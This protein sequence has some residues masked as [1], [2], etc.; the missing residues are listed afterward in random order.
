M[1][2]H[3]LLIRRSSST[4]PHPPV[5]IRRSSSTGPHPPALTHRSSS[6]GPHPLVLIHL[7][8]HRTLGFPL[9]ESS[10]LPCPAASQGSSEINWLAPGF[11]NPTCLGKVPQF[12]DMVTG[13]A[14]ILW[15]NSRPQDRCGMEIATKLEEGMSQKTGLVFRT[16]DM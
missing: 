7:T 13:R 5:L 11:V 12:K 15:V 14:S 2:S 9:L 16:D 3:T 6:T 8:I 1:V 4:G 10:S